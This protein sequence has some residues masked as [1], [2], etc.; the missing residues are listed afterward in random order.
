[1]ANSKILINTSIII[2]FL[3]KKDKRKSIFWKIINKYDCCVS[4]IT[5]FELFCGANTSDKIEHNLP[6]ATLNKKHFIKIG[7]LELLD[8]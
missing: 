3:R 8:Y 7:Q 1:M 5:H 4:T 2:D 6:L